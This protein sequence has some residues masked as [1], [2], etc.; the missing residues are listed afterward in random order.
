MPT[1][2][3]PP[4]KVRTWRDLYV[5]AL[6]ERDLLAL[7]SLIDEAEEAIILRA[8]ELRLPD[9]ADSEEREALDDVLYAPRALRHS[10][11]LKTS[12]SEVAC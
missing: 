10:L 7:P 5:D 8:C 1:T 2:N 6:L 4:V 11:E 3:P 12:E 9:I